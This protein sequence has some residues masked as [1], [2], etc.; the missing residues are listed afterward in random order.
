MSALVASGLTDFLHDAVEPQVQADAI[1]LGAVFALM[2]VGIGLVFGVLRLINFAYG[3]LIMAG[4]FALAF[5]S[6][7][8]WPVVAGIALCVAVVVGLSLVMERIVFR[9]LRGQSPASMLI[10]TFAVAFLLQSI[11]LIWF[12]P[13]GKNATSLVELNQP[14]SIGSV[15]VR[16]IAVVSL[17]TAVVALLLLLLLLNRTAIGLHMRA[18]ALDFANEAR[19]RTDFGTAGGV[20]AEAGAVALGVAEGGVAGVGCCAQPATVDY[21]GMP[22]VVFTRPQLASAGLTE[23]KA[24]T[25]G[26]RCDCRVLALADVPRALANRD[27]RGVIKL[28]ADADTGQYWACT[29]P[30]RKL[31]R[32]C[33]PPPTR[34]RRG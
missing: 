27:S 31:G 8:G 34:S 6:E 19:L 16:K 10:A 12:G 14:M 13:L 23:A 25:G 7:R 3:Q 4:G 1:G 28:V 9:P 21:T 33:S 24:L 20:A 15:E 11:A 22:A 2:A 18:A 17:V 5:A 30:P 26:H 32:S 29:P